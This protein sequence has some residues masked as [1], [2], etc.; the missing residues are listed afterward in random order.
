MNINLFLQRLWI[1]TEGGSTS[2]MRQQAN[3]QMLSCHSQAQETSELCM[4]LR[5]PLTGSPSPKYK[6]KGSLT[7]GEG[8]EILE[9]GK[10]VKTAHKVSLLLE[11]QPMHTFWYCLWENRRIITIFVLILSASVVS[12]TV[13][14]PSYAPWVFCLFLFL[15]PISK[16]S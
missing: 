5:Y 7:W 6:V 16:V 8:P 1:W 9:D 4:W 13:P 2:L 15:K 11:R 14:S 10:G 3:S 12:A